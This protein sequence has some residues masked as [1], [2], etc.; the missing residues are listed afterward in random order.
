M[1]TA[2]KL[3]KLIIQDKKIYLDRFMNPEGN[4]NI[5]IKKEIAKK[6]YD[7]MKDMEIYVNDAIEYD[8]QRTIRRNNG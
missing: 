7:R 4:E 5:E 8:K 1:L 3:L 2:R 6:A